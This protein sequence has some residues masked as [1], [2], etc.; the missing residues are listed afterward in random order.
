LR[1]F[2]EIEKLAHSVKS[3]MSTSVRELSP[4]PEPIVP[5]R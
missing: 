2:A 5:V 3:K 1:E 4:F